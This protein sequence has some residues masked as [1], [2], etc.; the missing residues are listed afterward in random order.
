MRG[1]LLPLIVCLVLLGGLGA[2]ALGQVGTPSPARAAAVRAAG[3]F[4]I[5]NSVDGTPIFAATGIAPGGSIKGKVTI[6]D[7]G[8]I[9]VALK[10]ERGELTDVAG[11]GGGL[12]SDHLQLTVA[13]VTKAG[14]PRAVYS[15]PLDSMPEQHAGELE[16][17]ASRTYEFTATL[18]DGAPSAQNAL[19]DASTTIAYSWVA[20][21]TSDGEEGPP[22]GEPPTE[23][24]KGKVPAETPSGGA[25]SRRIGG[26]EGGPGRGGVAGLD[27]TVPK[28]LSSLRA[29]GVVTF[30]DCDAPCRIFVRGKLRTSAHGHRHTAKVRFSLKRPYMPGS[31][32]MR[33]PIPRGMRNWLRQVSTPKRLKARLRFVAVGTTGGRDVVMKKVRLRVRARHH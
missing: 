17:G 12:L 23:E 29:G 16:P 10:L 27:L 9:P 3:A 7:P 25:E 2:V 32:R 4:E 33:I 28:I 20:E 18:P 21:E 11:I 24:A 15:G 19:Q 31:K 13:D 6:E 8:S 22:Q 30:V 14:A 5:S 1:R 26:G